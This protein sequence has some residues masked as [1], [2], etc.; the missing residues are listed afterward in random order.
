MALS[1]YAADLRAR[2]RDA[3]A[4]CGLT[5]DE[6]RAQAYLEARFATVSGYS[7]ALRNRFTALTGH[8]DEVLWSFVEAIPAMSAFADSVVEGAYALLRLPATHRAAASR[9]L[10]AYV[11]G[12]SIFD[13]AT[14]D[15]RALLNEIG[16]DLTEHLLR[17]VIV[18]GRASFGTHART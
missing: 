12:S 8:D 6:S 7:T 18:E 14:D 11:I 2:T 10:A 5:F 9:A 13:H 15:D 17:E 3:L 16:Q 1:G 4:M